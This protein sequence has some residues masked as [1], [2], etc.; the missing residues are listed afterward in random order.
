MFVLL[1]DGCAS[2]QDQTR[3]D[4]PH[5]IVHFTPPFDT[6]SDL[7]VITRFDDLPVK[8]GRDYRV[9][10]DEH[11]LTL[12]VAT[13]DSAL[14]SPAQFGVGTKQ[15][16]EERSKSEL[17]VSPTGRLDANTAPPLFSGVQMANIR[18][19]SRQILYA[20]NII[21]LEAGRRYELEPN[22]VKITPLASPE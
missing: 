1:T 12:R 10:P 14:Y 4:Q 21:I 17:T 2:L 18:V 13:F 6:R 11:R 20:T 5:A 22:S 15:L 3:K 8:T 16:A 7:T 19:D 9:A